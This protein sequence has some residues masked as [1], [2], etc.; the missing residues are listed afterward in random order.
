MITINFAVVLD[1]APNRGDITIKFPQGFAYR[2]QADTLVRRIGF[3]GGKAH[4]VVR[5]QFGAALVRQL[6]KTMR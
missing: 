5:N 1:R 3:V 4:V 2:D 6:N